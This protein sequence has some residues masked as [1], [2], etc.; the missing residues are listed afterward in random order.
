MADEAKLVL[1][2]LEELGVPNVAVIRGTDALEAAA[3]YTVQIA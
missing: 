1:D 2:A 3:E